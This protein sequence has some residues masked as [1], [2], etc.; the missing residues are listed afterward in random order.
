MA[1]S[2]NTANQETFARALSAAFAG[3]LG[4]LHR[5]VIKAGYRKPWY[6]TSIFEVAGFFGVSTTTIKQ[7][8][9]G[10]CPGKT[11]D[12]Y[13][14]AAM[15]RW[16]DE[17]DKAR[18]QDQHGNGAVPRDARDR[19]AHYQAEL[20]RIRYETEVGRYVKRDEYERALVKRSGWFVNVLQW[21][22]GALAPVVAGKT[23]T[24]ARRIIRERC[25]EVQKSAYGDTT[26]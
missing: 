19:R 7:W 23:V 8:W 16:R 26:G 22:P 11:D 12:G 15:L 13:D 1:K 17:R 5:K 25:R 14:L 20:T 6:A 21:L 2:V 10:G 24:E 9:S 3:S 18:A 4:W